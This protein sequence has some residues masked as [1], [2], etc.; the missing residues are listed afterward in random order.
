MAII[1]FFQ[2]N[3]SSSKIKSRKK[4]KS[5]VHIAFY[6]NLLTLI[7]FLITVEL[8]SLKPIATNPNPAVKP[9]INPSPGTALLLIVME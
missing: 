2:V 7:A 5:I 4:K 6:R 9:V 1:S 3:S 8:P